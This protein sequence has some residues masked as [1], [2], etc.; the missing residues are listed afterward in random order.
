MLNPESGQLLFSTFLGTDAVEGYGI[1]RGN[2]VI[3][4]LQDAAYFFGEVTGG[5]PAALGTFWTPQ[6]NG[7]T[8]PY[9]VKLRLSCSKER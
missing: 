5:F 1:Q 7:S 9:L 4:G 8:D 3:V 6:S 2:G